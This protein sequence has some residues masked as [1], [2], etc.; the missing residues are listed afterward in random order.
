MNRIDTLAKSLFDLY[1]KIR[2]SKSSVF[3]KNY[4]LLRES[5]EILKNQQYD[6]VV[7]GEV[8]KGKSSFINALLGQYLLPVDVQVATSQVFRIT[9]SD[10]EKFFL[11]YIDGSEQEITKDELRQYGSQVEA[12]K[13]GKIQYDDK[14]VDYIQVYAKMPFL[15]EGVSIVDTPGLGALYTA[16]EE[17]TRRYVSKAAAV[18]FVFDPT[19]PMTKPECEFIGRVLDITPYIMFV[20]TKIDLYPEAYKSIMRRNEDLLN[21]TFEDIFKRPVE[22]Y[23]ISSRILYEA[24]RDNDEFAYEDS[25][26][27]EAKTALEKLIEMTVALFATKRAWIEISKAK[28]YIVPVLKE[29]IIV[30]TDESNALARQAEQKRIGLLKQLEQEWGNNGNKKKEFLTRVDAI[31]TG[32]SNKTQTLFH[33]TNDLYKEYEKRIDAVDSQDAAK[34]LADRL[35]YELQNEIAQRWQSYVASA[36]SSLNQLL[37]N[38][39][40]EIGKIFA[41]PISGLYAE[42]INFDNTKNRWFDFFRQDF[43]KIGFGAAL[44]GLVLPIPAAIGALAAAIGGAFW[45]ISHNETHVL[46]QMKGQLKS[47]LQENFAKLRDQII[48]VPVDDGRSPLQECMYSIKE[49]AKDSIEKI[50]KQFEEQTKKEIEDMQET[51]TKSKEEKLKEMMELKQLQTLWEKTISKELDECKNMIVEIESKY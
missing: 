35:P 38:Y 33:T 17:I 34:E 1:N 10:E 16:H 42:E 40:E 29:R 46:E 48:L 31:L 7:C 2:I 51:V 19:A 50:C 32:L 27:P 25:L 12:N 6:I 39:N 14:V 11:K 15:P 37:I 21:E 18:V 30:L 44:A 13:N 49:K 47:S 26:F 9:N 20:L 24:S 8:K 3:F 45:S 41:H 43:L 23:P 5:E 4:N 36:E 22:I 28:D